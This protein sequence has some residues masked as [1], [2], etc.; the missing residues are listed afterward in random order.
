MTLKLLIMEGI[1]PFSALFGNHRSMSPVS[2]DIELGIELARELLPRFRYL[3]EGVGKEWN[4]LAQSTSHDI[5]ARFKR[6]LT[7]GQ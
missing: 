6:L 5:D 1:E 4:K 3:K 7:Q 2:D